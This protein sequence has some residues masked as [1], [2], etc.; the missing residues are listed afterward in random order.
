MMLVNIFLVIFLAFASGCKLA[1]DATTKNIHSGQDGSVKG[2]MTVKLAQGAQEC[3]T[4]TDVTPHDK[5]KY[6]T[7]EGGNGFLRKDLSNCHFIVTTVTDSGKEISIYRTMEDI[8]ALTSEHFCGTKST[9]VSG[10]CNDALVAVGNFADITEQTSRLATGWD[11]YLPST[12]SPVKAIYSHLRNQLDTA[13]QDYR[14]EITNNEF[15]KR[16][17]LDASAVENIAQDFTHWGKL[18]P[19]F[20]M[21]EYG[22]R[23]HGNA[24]AEAVY[25]DY[26]PTCFKLV[27]IFMQQLGLAATKKYPLHKNT[28]T[29]SFSATTT[30]PYVQE[31]SVS[32][33]ELNAYTRYGYSEYSIGT[34]RFGAQSI[35]L[36]VPL[37]KAQMEL[38]NTLRVIAREEGLSTDQQA[39]ISAKIKEYIVSTKKTRFIIKEY[40]RQQG[41]P[42]FKNYAEQ[43][44]HFKE[45]EEK[46]YAGFKQQEDLDKQLFNQQQGKSG[47][48]KQQGKSGYNRRPQ[49]QSDKQLSYEEYVQQQKEMQKK[50]EKEQ[51]QERSKYEEEQRKQREEFERQQRQGR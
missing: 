20:L 19:L 5:V 8:I 7:M 42:V 51:Q 44:K 22:S 18:R 41:K 17:D 40:R 3:L 14:V 12:S 30:S 27:S 50:F 10:L 15:L 46:Q 21:G 38:E 33:N 6:T 35:I 39:Q 16:N 31:G 32:L 23:E 47:Y 24:V 11:K 34:K 4:S 26:L 13:A 48:Q 29:T 2:K 9:Q 1:Q 49:G 36:I 28:A 25:A 43:E 45:Q 37:L